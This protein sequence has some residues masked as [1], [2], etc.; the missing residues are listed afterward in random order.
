MMGVTLDTLLRR[1]RAV[2]LAALAT[3]TALAWLYLVWGG[4]QHTGGSAAAMA[5]MNTAV[6]WSAADFLL[7]F[8]MWAVMMVGMMT[9]SV[10]PMLLTYSRVA[11]NANER[12]QP[13]APTGWFAAGY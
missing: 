12:A 9:P 5:D 10:A 3:V 7:M 13:F 6:R 8:L 1:D 2:V 4:T 11:R